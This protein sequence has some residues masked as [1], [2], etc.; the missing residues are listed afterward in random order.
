MEKIGLK[1]DFIS[2]DLLNPLLTDFYQ[3]TMIYAYWKVNRHNETA[4]FDLFYRKQPY[5]SSVSV[6]KYFILNLY[7]IAYSLD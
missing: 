4:T 5:K 3:Y 7:S 6:L 2:K 1:S